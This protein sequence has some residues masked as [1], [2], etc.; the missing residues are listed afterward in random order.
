M[1]VREHTTRSDGHTSEKLV[2]LLIILD[3][4]SDVAGDDTALLV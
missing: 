3:G 4:K 2:E 1:D